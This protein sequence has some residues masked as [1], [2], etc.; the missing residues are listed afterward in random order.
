VGKNRGLWET[1]RRP[2]GLKHGEGRRL[3]EETGGKWARHEG[4][5][6]EYGCYSKGSR[7]LWR[8]YMVK[9]NSCF[10]ASASPPSSSL[11][12]PTALKTGFMAAWNREE[13]PQPLP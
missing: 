6:K 2:G 10:Q 12:K 7:E 1:H 3:R 5:S 13:F 11:I 4:Q 9:I 8:D